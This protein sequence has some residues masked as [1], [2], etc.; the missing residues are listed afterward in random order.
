MLNE[1]LLTREVRKFLSTIDLLS[2]QE[3]ESAVKEAVRAKQL[4]GDETL[5]AR[6]TLEIAEIKL[7][8]ELED[9]IAL[10]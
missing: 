1:K 8:I 7:E 6:M 4:T 3:I 5:T 10:S 2:Q 9:T